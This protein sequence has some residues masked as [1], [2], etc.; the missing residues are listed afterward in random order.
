VQR[1]YMNVQCCAMKRKYELKRRAERQAET[2]RR[3]VA[4]AVA[5][6]STLGPA[7]TTISAI[8]EHAGVQRH[9]VYAHFPDDAA[10]FR[11]C[12]SHWRA[13]NPVPDVSGLE[14]R[15]ALRA[16]YDWYERTERPVTLFARDSYLHPDIWAERERKLDEIAEELARPLGRRRVVRAA[17]GHAIGFETWR[18]LVRSEGLSNAQAAD[19]MAAFV[20]SV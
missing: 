2:R 7:K 12:S 16:L 18:S 17:V 20:R 11:A 9:T 13:Q 15:E 14:L 10:L 4:A 5:L 1:H 8:A 3:I 19:A 6:H